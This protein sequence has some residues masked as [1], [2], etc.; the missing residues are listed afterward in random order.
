L[1]KVI[2]RAEQPHAGQS[3]AVDVLRLLQATQQIGDLMLHADIQR[4]L[5]A[6]V[7][8]VEIV[9]TVDAKILASRVRSVV[10]LLRVAKGCLSM[11]GVRR[12]AMRSASAASRSPGV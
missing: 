6:E 1:T 11:G 10:A 3:G 9:Q 8:A 5:H 12:S 2:A 4:A 7:E